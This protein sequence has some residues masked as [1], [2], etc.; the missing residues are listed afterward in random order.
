MESKRVLFITSS[1]PFHS[2]EQFIETE[3]LIW[4]RYLNSHPNMRL[5]ILPHSFGN[6]VVRRVPENFEVDLSFAHYNDCRNGRLKKLCNYFEHL[7]KMLISK[8]FASE[9]PVFFRKGL[10]AGISGILSLYSYSRCF[11]FFSDFF[12][13]KQLENCRQHICYTYWYNETT[14]ALQ[15]LKSI[16]NYKLFTRTHGCDLYEERRKTKHIPLRRQFLK[17]IDNVF[18]I[19]DSAADYLNLTF[20]LP[21]DVIV[22]SRLGVIDK[23]ILTNTGATT[24]TLNI[25]SCSYIVPVKRI[26]KIIY[27]LKVL[28]QNVKYEIK[29]THIGSGS[30][31]NEIRMLAQTEL[32]GLKNLTYNFLGELSNEGVFRFYKEN[33]VDVFINVSDSEGVP[34]SLMEAMSC[35]I[36]VIGPNVG[37]VSDMITTNLN[38][39]LLPPEPTVE[40]IAEALNKT[41]LFKSPIVRKNSHNVFLQKYSAEVNYLD[42]ISK[43][44]D[45]TWTGKIKV[46]T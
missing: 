13:R 45:S 35:H 25:V 24:N 41:E 21:K 29:W 16:Y 33:S 23:S 9:L 3:V 40:E 4:E 12:K 1:F 15:A 6:G 17:D 2:G 44:T 7:P 32:G 20:G 5:T 22:T 26:D 34:V 46:D 37:G 11:T 31:E 14:Y 28:S 8:A 10:W 19:T 42:F 39:I 43:I 30:H 18:T 27:A 38:G 36:P